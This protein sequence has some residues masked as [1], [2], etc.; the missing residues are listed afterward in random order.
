[1]KTTTPVEPSCWKRSAYPP[2]PSAQQ[3]PWLALAF[4]VIMM[5]LSMALLQTPPPMPHLPTVSNEV[6]L[7]QQR[8]A[9]A[10][11]ARLRQHDLQVAH[12]GQ[13]VDTARTETARSYYWDEFQ[14]RQEQRGQLVLE[15][16]KLVDHHANAGNPVLPPLGLSA[17]DPRHSK[18]QY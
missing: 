13:L 18:C 1:M 17:E 8:Y 12:W 4:L 10:L 7:A 6:Q 3:L 11:C 14:V 9:Q 2:V 16:F 15:H 5:V